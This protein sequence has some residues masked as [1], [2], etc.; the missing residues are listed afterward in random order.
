MIQP[1]SRIDLAHGG[2][3]SAC[4]RSRRTP[5][6]YFAISIDSEMMASGFLIFSARFRPPR[7]PMLP[8]R[9]GALDADMHAQRSSD[10]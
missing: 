8:G 5:G 3:P 1:G 7:R 2:C 9:S 6:E 4:R 10:H